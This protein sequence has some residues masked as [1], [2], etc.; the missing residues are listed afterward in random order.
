[1][2]SE[3]GPASSLAFVP[4]ALA[5]TIAI[6]ILVLSL[7]VAVVRPFGLSEAVV[8][9]PGAVVVVL[10]GIVSSDAARD[11]LEQIGPTVGFLAA[12]LVFGHLCAEAGVFAYL[13]ARAARAS[14][15]RPRR[16]LALVV[17]LAAGVT[18]VLTL[19]ATV[20]LLTPVVLTTVRQMRIAARPHLYACT[21]LANS[22]S[23]L[24][25][26]SNLT[27]LLAFAASGLAFGHFA[28]L[29][30]VPWLL[31]CLVEWLGLRT[32][33]RTDLP[34]EPAGPAIALPSAPRYALGILALTVAG[35]VVT[36]SLDVNP[37]WA[38]LGGCL[39]LLLP[40]LRTGDISVRRLIGEASPGFCLFVLALAVIVDGV[41]AHGLG[42]ALRHLMPD[43]TT[44]AA[45]LLTALLAAAVANLVNNLPA[46]LALIP[47]VA[48]QPVL[49]LAVL[50]GV[51]V[52]PNATYPGSLAT[53]LWR[54]L[55]PADLRPNAGQFHLLGILTVPLIVAVTTVAL[56]GGYQLIG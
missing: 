17:L 19:D 43:T 6:A 21:H 8:A 12:I 16:L 39:L 29:M 37:A 11:R 15:G 10:T 56:W 7:F 25:P 46:T 5:E 2:L 45:L 34:A 26:V 49:V 4:G 33:F 35:F 31:A 50:I 14:G 23:L 28:A 52:G 41:T 44:L 53:L 20:V 22:G 18:A 55:L 47:I 27:N 54:R 42:T 24:L 9:V 30:V 1:M 40:R 13:G 36:S 3:S 48:G 51:N 38:A 32:F